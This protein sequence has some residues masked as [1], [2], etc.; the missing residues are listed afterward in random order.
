VTVFGYLDCFGGLERIPTYRYLASS[1]YCFYAFTA[2]ST[3]CVVKKTTQY[4]LCAFPRLKRSISK[5]VINPFIVEMT[6]NEASA[7]RFVVPASRLWDF[8]RIKLVF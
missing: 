5:F 1:A 3:V 6:R 8:K 2:H 4:V 7:L